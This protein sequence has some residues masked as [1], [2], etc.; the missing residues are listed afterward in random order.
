MI[1]YLSIGFVILKFWWVGKK[2]YE[3]IWALQIRIIIW[4]KKLLMSNTFNW[5]EWLSNFSQLVCAHMPLLDET[6][7][8]EDSPIMSM[9]QWHCECSL[10]LVAPC[11]NA[12]ECSWVL[13]S[14]LVAMAPCS[15]VLIR[16]QK[17]QCPLISDYECSWFY[18]AKILGVHRC[19]W[20]FMSTHE[21]PSALMSMVTLQKDH[22]QALISI[23][24]HEAMA[25][26]AMISTHSAIASYS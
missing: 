16:S 22:S 14:D 1:F 18:G 15:W 26:R 13:M 25:P 23:H 10:M 21:Q 19:P 5:E 3:F 17:S 8:D 20:A 24:E 2:S 6:I 11:L 4:R 12:Q 7:S 9:W